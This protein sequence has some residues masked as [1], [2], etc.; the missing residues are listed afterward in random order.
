G[1]DFAMLPVLLRF[2][3]TPVTP[4]PTP[5]P[6]LGRPPTTWMPDDRV[7]VP[8]GRLEQDQRHIDPVPEPAGAAGRLAFVEPRGWAMPE[9]M[10]CFSWHAR[11]LLRGMLTGTL[12][13][14]RCHSGRVRPGAAS[15]A[16][17]RR[18]HIEVPPCGRVLAVTSPC[19][20]S[21]RRRTMNSPMPTP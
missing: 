2:T 13:S 4:D 9:L 1:A 21:A 15:S 19:C 10:K 20:A 16:G 12:D 17:R 6:S 18:R 7:D 8:L 11:L 5:P 14:A 3:P